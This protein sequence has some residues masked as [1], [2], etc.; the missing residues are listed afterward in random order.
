MKKKKI[1]LTLK[2]MFDILD[3]CNKSKCNDNCPYR[4]DNKC[5]VK[6]ID[7][8]DFEELGLMNLDKE[9]EVKENEIH[10]N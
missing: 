8:I 7:Y 5:Q 2:E 10:K 4:K 6:F 1:D 9:I 3:V